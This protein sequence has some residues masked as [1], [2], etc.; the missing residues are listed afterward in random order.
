LCE[1]VPLGDTIPERCR[2]EFQRLVLYSLGFAGIL[3]GLALAQSQPLITVD[4]VMTGEELRVTGIESL[5]SAPT[6]CLG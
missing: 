2:M 6:F 4:Q 1:I 3:S 5:T